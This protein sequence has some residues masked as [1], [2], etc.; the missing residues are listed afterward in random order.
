MKNPDRVRETGM[1]C[2][3][4]DEIRDPELPD[5]PEALE[6]RGIDQLPSQLVERAIIAKTDQAMH[7]IA[8]ALG[9]SGSHIGIMS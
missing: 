8:Q 7:G 9:A 6:F 4:E 5:S 1:G 2:T 3:G